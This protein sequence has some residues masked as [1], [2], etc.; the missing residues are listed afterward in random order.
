MEL[1]GMT[2]SLDPTTGAIVHLLAGTG[3]NRTQLGTSD[4][5]SPSHPVA[6]FAYVTHDNEQA[7][8]FCVNHSETIPTQGTK[9]LDVCMT[10]AKRM[11]PSA[12]NQAWAMKVRVKQGSVL[13][14][15]GRSL[16]SRRRAI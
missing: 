12:R 2:L 11:I 10:A 1:P 8:N 15:M 9:T 13:A 3:D 14:T 6:R 7:Q 4:W 16:Q 5:A